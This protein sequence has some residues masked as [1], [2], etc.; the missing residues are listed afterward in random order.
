MSGG[1]DQGRAAFAEMVRAY[2]GGFPDYHCV[3]D[4]Q[5]AETDRV[6]TRWTFGGTQTG[7]LMGMLPT[8]NHVTVTGVA[9]DRILDGQL[10]ESWLEMDAQRMLQDLG[11]AS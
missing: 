3:I 5:I 11:V 10:V 8:G 1:L 9:I 2:R 4:D 6:V 7:H